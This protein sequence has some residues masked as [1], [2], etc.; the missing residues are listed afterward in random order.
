MRLA[1][2]E[3]KKAAVINEVPV[4]AI[5]VKDEQVIAKA[6]NQRET[7][8]NA[9][10]HAEILAIEKACKVLGD[11]RLD[12]CVLFV[13]LEPCAMCGG[14]AY[15]SRLKGIVYGA[16]DPKGGSLGGTFDLSLVKGFNHQ[17]F[18]KSSVLEEECANII[19]E[20]FKNKRISS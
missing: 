15:L 14:A 12:E 1:L 3:A 13:T 4:G 11:W 9:V 17:P 5:I 20:F 10:A 16:N 18:I 19:S 2:E 6:H 8:R 7:T